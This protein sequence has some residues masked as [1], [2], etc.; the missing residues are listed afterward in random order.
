[1]ANL[2]KDKTV[3]LTGRKPEPS[4]Q[5]NG[6]ILNQTVLPNTISTGVKYSLIVCFT[7]TVVDLNGCAAR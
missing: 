4:M 7:T 5:S 2:T 6:A 1:M 3:R